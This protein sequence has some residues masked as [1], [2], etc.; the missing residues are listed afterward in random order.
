TQPSDLGLTEPGHPLLGAAIE[1]AS[2]QLTVLTA[3]LSTR[4]QPW[5][6]DHAVAGTVLLPGTA[7]VDL[8]LAAARRTGCG[9]LDELT[10]QAP[11]ILPER[12]AVRLQV[13]VGAPDETG[14]RTIDIH[15]RPDDSADAPNAGPDLDSDQQWTHHATGYLT[16]EPT[17]PADRTQ[18]PAEDLTTWPP[19]GADPVDVANLYP[20]LAEAG[21]GYGPM[22]HGL[23]AAWR[24]G[25]DVYAE[26]RLPEGTEATGYGIHPALLDACLHAPV[27]APGEHGEPGQGVQLP[28]SWAGVTLHASGATALRVRLRPTGDRSLTLAAAD[29]AGDPVLTINSLIT[30]P[31]SPEA[32]TAA[33]PTV[34]RHLYEVEWTAI[35][36]CDD[37]AAQ[38]ALLDDPDRLEELDAADPAATIV[39]YACE[40]PAGTQPDAARAATLRVLDLA[41]QWLAVPRFAASRLAI[42]TTR[43][44][45]AQ[46]GEHI[47]DLAHAAVWG[48]IRSAQNENPGRFVLVDTDGTEDSRRALAKALATAVADE[49]P[50]LAIRAGKFH[51]PRL[52]RTRQDAAL[53]I[54]PAGPESAP[55]RLDSTGTGTVDGVALVPNPGAA[56][57]LEP[58]QIRVALRAAGLNFRDALIALGMYPGRAA[59][60]SEGAG[61]V[62]ETAPDVTGLRPGDRVMGLMPGGVGPLS[63]TDHR[64]V[65][66]IPANWSFAQAAGAPIVFLTAYYSLIDLGALQPGEKLLIHAGT[67]GVGMAALQLARHLGLDV[68]TTA[69]PPKWPTLRALGV[70][71]E[72]IASSRT[73]DFERKFRDLTG[74]GVDA[75]LNSL[76]GDFND[77]SLRLLKPGGRFLEMG[78]T[79]I[80][81]PESLRGDIAYTA[82]DMTDAGPDRIQEMLAALREL[83]EAGA[84]QPLPVT[85][86]DIRDA[87]QALRHLSQARHT[88]KLV[89]TLPTPLDPD[90][91]VL[92]TGATGNL[93]ALAARHLVAEHGVRHLILASRRGAS[94]PGANDLAAE[95]TARGAVVKLVACDAADRD[96]LAAL[97]ADVP[98]EHPLTGL[99]HTAGVV[100]DATVTALTAEQVGAVFAPKADAAWNLHTLTRG[101]DLAMF[102]TYSSAAGVFGNPGQANYAAANSYLDA[103]AA[104][105]RISG[106][107][108]TALAWGSWQPAAGMTAK[109]GEADLARMRRGGMRPLPPAQGM[110]LFDAAVAGGRAATVPALLDLSAFKAAGSIPALLRAL[111]RA[112]V[113]TA[114]TAANPGASSLARRLS[115]LSPEA[116]EQAL[117]QLILENATAVLGHADTGAVDAERP[118][119]DLGFDSLTAVELRNR[120]GTATGLRLSPTLTF[121]YPTPLAL[122]RHLISQ[123]LGGGSTEP[124]HPADDRLLPATAGLDDD[125]IAIVGMAC[126]FPGGVQSPEDL[127]QLV[128]TERDAIGELPADRGWNLA[129]LYDP[130]PQRPGT[131]YVRHGGFIDASGFDPGFFGINPREALAM[132]PQQRLLLET[133]W[134]AIE[135]AGID[136]AS[137]RASQTGVFAGV[138][139]QGYSARLRDDAPDELEGYLAT[140]NTPSV[141]SGRVSYTFGFEGPAI[142]VD[143]ACSSSLV[144]IHLACQALRNR[145]CDLALSGGVTVMATPTMF[146]EFSRQRGL[147]PDGRCKAFSADADGTAWGE[148]AGM[149]LLERLSDARR[150][151]HSVLAIVRGS[152]VNQDGASNGLTAPNGPSQE[153]VIR[154]ALK[155]AALTSADIDV[156]EAHGTGTPLGDPIEAQ[157]LLATYGRRRPPRSP[158]RLGSVKSNIGHTQAASGVAGVLKMVMAMRHGLL[159]RTLHATAATPHVDWSSGAVSLLTESVPWP[160]TGHPRRAAVSSFAISGTNAHVILEAADAC[161]N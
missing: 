96:A 82:F 49:E 125:P 11:L 147:A 3:Q 143:T 116:R 13:T 1:L 111:V 94:A 10:L 90:G 61:V 63:V 21:Y 57:P 47:K 25:T 4:R 148:G 5:L 58:G 35:R 89:L 65:T 101:A 51:A 44:V 119:K 72:R 110:A 42:V 59:I 9:L 55:W 23:R 129:A 71:E 26:V 146:V 138:V 105:R 114:A 86:W 95:L 31:V 159:P 2:G 68:Y 136:P 34:N 91:T 80:R 60:G 145:E 131:S 161:G 37:A 112:P 97:L 64:L 52:T 104:H 36:P 127:W 150:N 74:D 128:A 41:R 85:A 75:V 132:D 135:Q 17:E 107:P 103:L 88:G 70:P 33:Q 78:K 50:Q 118:F 133:S 66:R 108:A 102:V 18:A 24:R 121:D 14:R 130:D 73:L 153:R 84:L 106:L 134:E 158:L 140:G 38:P 99:V 39:V 12:D 56:E 152:A 109:L 122:A 141:A 6:A 7:F 151:G 62:V 77:A 83:I 93:G 92:V 22:F 87:R 123:G 120:L 79:D 126:R 30:R 98:A 29:P 157:A 45:T 113:R 142:T 54:P 27:L 156:V 28:F 160:E 19:T 48:L 81:T 149:V 115:G 15:S 144:A 139:A 69:G 40:E 124:Q 32:L 43:A 155:A 100:E 67:G 8:A 76:A 20:A 46:P 154:Q 137:L 16:A 117:L 53:P